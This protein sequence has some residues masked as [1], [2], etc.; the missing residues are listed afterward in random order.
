M[1]SEVRLFKPADASA[2]RRIFL[3][4]T[5]A[6]RPLDGRFPDADVLADAWT[7]YYIEEEP[8]SLWVAERDAHVVGYL[9]GC[10]DERRFQARMRR[11]IVPALLVK[12]LFRGIWLKPL[13]WRLLWANRSL[14]HAPDERATIA[15]YPGHFH[16]N[17]ADGYRRQGLGR[18]LITQFL[19]R[20][21]QAGC[22]GVRAETG[23]GN[24]SIHHLLESLGFTRLH[25]APTFRWADD[26]LPRW[27]VTYARAL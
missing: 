23:D 12:G 8:E 6:G 25:R 16:V 1:D 4:T 17:L 24:A 11:R 14:A 27:K 13:F 19:A 26:P 5:D 22:R 2:V 3:D 21:G 20:A 9:S 10:L 7:R 15:Q 18:S